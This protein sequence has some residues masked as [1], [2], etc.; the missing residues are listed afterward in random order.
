MPLKNEYKRAKQEYE[1]L[2]ERMADFKAKQNVAKKELEKVAKAI[3]ELTKGKDPQ[4]VLDTLEKEIESRRNMVEDKV[5][6]FQ[7][8]LNGRFSDEPVSIDQTLDSS[9]DDIL[10]E[11][12]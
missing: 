12:L 9:S 5:S 10:G 11:D 2:K 1:E 3:Q 4:T 7:R 8:L 6:E